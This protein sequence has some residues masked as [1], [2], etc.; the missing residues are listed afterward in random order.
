MLTLTV[1]F[2]G[3][4]SAGIEEEKRLA[5]EASS[6]ALQPLQLVFWS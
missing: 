2:V 5:E 4:V 1:M 6:L 3:R